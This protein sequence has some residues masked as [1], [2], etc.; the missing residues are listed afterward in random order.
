MQTDENYSPSALKNGKGSEGQRILRTLE[1]QETMN[2]LE[3]AMVREQMDFGL[4]ELTKEETKLV[5]VVFPVFEPFIVDTRS[6]M[7]KAIFGQGFSE[8]YGNLVRS[9]KIVPVLSITCTRKSSWN[10]N[11]IRAF[12]PT[13]H[14]ALHGSFPLSDHSPC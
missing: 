12:P 6:T 10:S 5:R 9:E 2:A 4:A 8:S 3:D 11:S 1:H 13:L 14:Q 7:G